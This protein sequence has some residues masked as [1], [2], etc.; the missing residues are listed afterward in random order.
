MKPYQ[1]RLGKTFVFKDLK[2]GAVVNTDKGP[3]VLITGCLKEFA[4]PEAETYFC[5][6]FDVGVDN[7]TTAI[8]D[9]ITALATTAQIKDIIKFRKMP[10][11]LRMAQQS[12]QF[13]PIY[14]DVGLSKMGKRAAGVYVRELKEIAKQAGLLQEEKEKAEVD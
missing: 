12:E 10:D 7:L 14:D 4:F 9:Q 11:V 6:L 13:R 2:A 8:R 1:P 5:E 3:K